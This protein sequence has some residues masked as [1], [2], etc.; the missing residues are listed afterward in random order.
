MGLADAVVRTIDGAPAARAAD[1]RRAGSRRAAEQCACERRSLPHFRQSPEY[2]AGHGM[3][4]GSP[5]AVTASAAPDPLQQP[6]PVLVRELAEERRVVAVRRQRVHA[7][8]AGRSRRRC[9]AG[10]V[11]PSKSEPKP[12]WSSPSRADQVVEVAQHRLPAHVRRAPRRRG[13][14]SR[15]RSSAPPCRRA[16]RSSASWRSV[17]FRVEG[18]D[19]VGVGMGRDQRRGRERRHVVEARRR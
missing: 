15:W 17:R 13:A 4:Y 8:P 14:G 2:H 16:R 7:A 9:P 3:P 12:T 19:R 11:A 6:E 10:S 5:L 1:A 18:R